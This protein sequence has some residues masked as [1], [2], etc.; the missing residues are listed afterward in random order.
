MKPIRF[1]PSSS[2]MGAI[3]ST[4]VFRHAG[5]ERRLR[6]LARCE[7]GEQG[8]ERLSASTIQDDYVPS[9]DGSAVDFCPRRDVMA[10][11][12][13]PRRLEI[14]GEAL[15]VA[16]QRGTFVSLGFFRLTDNVLVYRNGGGGEASNSHGSTGRERVSARRENRTIFYPALSPDGAR[17][18]I[19]PVDTSRGW[20]LADRFLAGTSTRFTFGPSA[21]TPIWSP[22]GNRIVFT[23]SNGEY[24]YQKLT[25]GAKDEEPLLKSTE[26]KLPGA[27]PVT[28]GSCCT[29]DSPKT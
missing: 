21:A 27:A 25:S 22:D 23:S 2:P 6:G 12:F 19:I 10:Q 29:S 24:V 4:C 11:P 28:E 13:D 20:P 17:V 1:C 26:N 14:S 16:E 3:S 7:A 5:K 8:L 9:S 18:A 15:I